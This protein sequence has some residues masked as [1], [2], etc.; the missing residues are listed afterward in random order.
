MHIIYIYESNDVDDDQADAMMMIMMMKKCVF[1][2]SVCIATHQRCS[3][4]RRRNIKKIYMQ[5]K[6][7]KYKNT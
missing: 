2:V 5:Q 1:F 3:R 4:K 6:R 7:Y